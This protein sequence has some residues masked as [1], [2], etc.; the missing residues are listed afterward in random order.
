MQTREE[1]NGFPGVEDPGYSCGPPIGTLGGCSHWMTQ[2]GITRD[3]RSYKTQLLVKSK[4]TP[5][6][7]ARILSS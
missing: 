6:F 4:K 1:T 3:E 7:T 5:G 2:N